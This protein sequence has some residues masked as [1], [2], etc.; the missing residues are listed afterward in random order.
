MLSA[1]K[2]AAERGRWA[3][4]WLALEPLLADP[5]TRGSFDVLVTAHLLALRLALD[6][7]RAWTI[8]G[9]RR[10]HAARRATWSLAICELLRTGRAFDALALA[11][12]ADLPAPRDA[13]ETIGAHLATA[14]VRSHFRD[15]ER[16]HEELAASE[17]IDA[18]DARIALE[19]AW[20]LQDEDRRADAL[21]VCR[22]ARA[23]APDEP[24]LAEQEC[25]LLDDAGHDDTLAVLAERAVSMQSPQIT[26]ML[27]ERRFERGELDAAESAAQRV[28]AQRPLGRRLHHGM[29]HL[30]VRI[31]RARGDDAGALQHARAGGRGLRTWTERLAAGAH[32]PRVTLP[33]PFVRQDHVTCSPATMAS[34]LAFHGQ[35]VP[36]AAIAARITYDGT[37]D[38]GELRWADEQGFAI[39]FFE[40]DA[41]AARRLIDLGQ[42]FAISMRS[43][44][45]G[46]RVAL[47]GYDAALDTFLLRDPGS[48]FVREV[49]AKWLTSVTAD[50]GGLCALIA[51]RDVLERVPQDVT[52]RADACVELVRLRHD[53]AERRLHDAARRAAAIEHVTEGTVRWEARFALANE[54]R[55]RRAATRLFAER[56]D[57]SP[58]DGYWQN[59]YAWALGNE[60]RWREMRE[61][62]EARCRRRGASPHLA[63]KLADH[64][65]ENAADRATAEALV[66]KA[67][68]RLGGDARSARALP[69]VIWHDVARRAEAAE[70]YRVVACLAPYDESLARS[71]ATAYAQIGRRDE[72]LVWL[73]ERV[74]R[75]GERSSD[76]S[77]TLADALRDAGR[78]EDA[79]D[80]LRSACVHHADVDVRFEL[81]DALL[82]AGHHDE[83]A[84]TLDA[85]GARGRPVDR[86]LAAHR[87]A[88]ARGHHADALRALD[89]A[90]AADP[91]ST[92]ALERRLHALLEHR[93]RDAALAVAD[94]AIAERGD[95]PRLMIVV[96]DFLERIEDRERAGALLRRLVDEHPDE[97]WLRA[98]L[99]THLV[100]TGAA[101][102]AL[103]ELAELERTMPDVAR[104]WLDLGRARAALGD[105]RA[106][107]AAARRALDVAPYDGYALR[108]ALEYA[109]DPAA[110]GAVF[111]DLA[112]RW[113]QEPGA[114]DADALR[115]YLG[116]ADGHVADAILERFLGDLEARF[117]DAR[118]L[119]IARVRFLESRDAAEALARAERLAAD[120]PWDP[121]LARL[122]GRCLRAVDRRDDERLVLEEVLA[123]YPNDAAAWVQLG[124]SH[125]D[126]GRLADARI[127]YERGLARVPGNAYL[128]GWLADVQWKLGERDAAL[129]SIARACELDR[130][131]AW[132]FGR[133]VL[134][135]GA[136]GREID[137]LGV[138]E[139]LVRSNPRWAV[140]HDVHATAL[141]QLGRHAERLDALRAALAI[142]P[143][144]GHA[145]EGLI[146]GLVE[147][148][149]F[150]EARAVVTEGLRLLGD[151]H[152]LALVDAR[153]LRTRGE[154]EASRTAL[155]ALLDAHPDFERGWITLLEWLEAEHRH[156]EILAIAK[157]VP[158]AL[159][160]SAVLHVYAADAHF[161]RD[162]FAAAE[163]A[164]G[165]ALAADP[166]HAW[167]K[168]RLATHLL[169]NRRAS[170]A[171]ELLGDD[172]PH[173]LPAWQ[174][175]L[176]ARAAAACGKPELAGRGFRRL[177]QHAEVDPTLLA[178]ADSALRTAAK[179]T[180]RA[181]LAELDRDAS[182][183]VRENLL[184]LAAM[185]G[186]ARGFYRGITRLCTDLPSP[187]SE[188]PIARLLYT[189]RTKLP[190]ARTAKWAK[191]H[192]RDPIADPEAFG[193]LAYALSGKDGA[194]VLAALAS[195]GWRRVG[196][197]A[198]M[199]ANVADAFLELGRLDD[200]IAVSRHALDDLPHDHSA[201]WHERFLREVA[202]RR[203]DAKPC[204]VHDRLPPA[205]LAAERVRW[206]AQR[207]LAKLRDEPSYRAR[208]RAL[209]AAL[210]QLLAEY[211]RA[212]RAERDASD[213]DDL[214][215]KELLRACPTLATLCLAGGW[216]GLRLGLS[217][218]ILRALSAPRSVA[219]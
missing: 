155:R 113:L 118:D 168:H 195:Q 152:D 59:A 105:T 4:A 156:E 132:A 121:E 193:R 135:L 97:P 22:A 26:A 119:R 185:R 117:A 93:G 98:R 169:A 216:F 21:A 8:R 94:T 10:D 41:S 3:E 30:L 36:Q 49:D 34:L 109:P 40:F 52:P 43:E 116:F 197:Q 124:S 172:D 101:D 63:I 187:A 161:A 24:R 6:T 134:W 126:D 189:A 78:P 205:E 160:D 201:W 176:V 202:L 33:V 50:K 39:R 186:D 157:Q 88:R 17:A 200:V 55:D 123:R 206:L 133:F 60:G 182:V 140:A 190:V 210:P 51:P 120:F 72:G 90:A 16:A 164:L 15:F 83:A 199:L 31:A 18:R 166:S 188:L 111:E 75:L 131:Y 48:S 167:A 58:D 82:V 191:A 57:A 198:W 53:L 144:I 96:L 143:R 163:A 86:E 23:A 47:C 154:L 218:A 141:G 142:D 165:R 27:A 64:I 91:C 2:S 9:L 204:L 54:H 110:A 45:S 122:R 77:V 215:G 147:L 196:V 130:D 214:R 181:V 95:D 61:F 178:D 14:R 1:V 68:R 136:V 153:I 203:G 179:R 150:D 208:R 149:R 80:V 5:I 183:V 44:N 19:R 145:R 67:L 127:S 217:L 20:T 99:A 81:F 104:T 46:H 56:L 65:R 71:C 12:R 73:R 32:G 212:R 74:D 207:L 112:A 194:A 138:A 125:E 102:D 115:A 38:H 103:R 213:P 87:L 69:D 192:L 92:L 175:A 100:N 219:R 79:L 107:H 146:D 106:A 66:R 25:W 11:T 114:P 89:R 35:V 76:P 29:H 184:H 211:S 158:A 209:R 13:E 108:L 70:L 148:K 85:I 139:E 28:L 180:R 42:P 174:A 128:H 162:D 129:R 7:R 177:L 37:P 151:D 137:A 159:A 84:A 171:L 62:L 173:S 170:A